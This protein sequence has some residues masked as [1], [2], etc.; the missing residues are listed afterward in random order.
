MKR[1]Y[2]EIL[3]ITIAATPGEVK[4]AYRSRAKK[5]H[6]DLNQYNTREA[7]EKFKEIGEAYGVLSDGV[8]REKYN[9]ENANAT[10]AAFQTQA[11]L[12]PRRRRRP[13]A[14][15]RKRR[16][17]GFNIQGQPQPAQADPQLTELQKSLLELAAKADGW[18]GRLFWLG[19]L[20]LSG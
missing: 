3:E 5:W 8:K 9:L 17:S 20:G 16:N 11:S 4:A 13:F 1:N 15:R 7:E 10:L 14:H 6:P 18:G 12:R 2:Y 19:L